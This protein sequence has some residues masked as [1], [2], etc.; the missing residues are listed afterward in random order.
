MAVISTKE[1]DVGLFMV[2]FMDLGI[3]RNVLDRCLLAVN[4]NNE[5]F[6]N[7]T[8][9]VKIRIIIFFFSL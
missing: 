4:P 1:V 8:V 9:N 3:T 7:D 2:P 5:V 6:I